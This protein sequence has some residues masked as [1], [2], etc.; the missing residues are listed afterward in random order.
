LRVE[1]GGKENDNMARGFL[2]GL[3]MQALRRLSPLDLQRELELL[4]T[5]FIPEA[6]SMYYYLTI[7][8]ITSW[9]LWELTC[10]DWRLSLEVC[11]DKKTAKY[12]TSVKE[13]LL[14]VAIDIAPPWLLSSWILRHLRYY[15]AG[16]EKLNVDKYKW[17]LAD[18]V[19][20]S[21][22]YSAYI[23]LLEGSARSLVEEITS[24]GYEYAGVTVY[25]IYWDIIHPIYSGVIKA[26]SQ[27]EALTCI[28]PLLEKTAEKE[29]KAYGEVVRRVLSATPERKTIFTDVFK[30]KTL[31]NTRCFVEKASKC[32]LTSISKLRMR[33][34]N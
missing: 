2:A 28:N 8:P 10:K 13:A 9:V 3:V 14:K 24:T 31:E 15:D 12:N 16:L 21:V 26:S 1:Q 23:A 33:E 11:R 22:N 5:L 20:D 27:D 19:A 6:I 34:D 25:Y 7:T 4:H 29:K 18:M 32:I 30:K 17:K